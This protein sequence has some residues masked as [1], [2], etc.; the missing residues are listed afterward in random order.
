MDDSEARS[1]GP[2]EQ[3]SDLSDIAAQCA[4]S[5]LLD[6]AAQLAGLAED[7]KALSSRPIAPRPTLA[8]PDDQPESR[9]SGII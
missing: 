2:I 8:E 9:F 5:N 3:A 4:V 6:V 1:A 7:L